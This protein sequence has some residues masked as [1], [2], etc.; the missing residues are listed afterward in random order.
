MSGEHGRSIRRS[1]SLSV[2]GSA[3]IRVALVHGGAVA[4][5]GLRVLLEQGGAFVVVAEAGKGAVLAQVFPEKGVVQVAVVELRAPFDAVRDT[6]RWLLRE[7]AIPVLA[8]GDLT[9]RVAAELLD[10]G[11]CGLLPADVEADE[12]QRACT[13]ASAGGYHVNTWIKGPVARGGK[14]KAQRGAG[15]PTAKQLEMLKWLYTGLTLEGIGVKMHIGRRGVETHRDA[16]FRKFG[17]HKLPL[18]LRV[19]MER[20][21]V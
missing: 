17:V 5:A 13:V 19:A 15:D 11:V 3:P 2:A 6:V 4:R 10:H 16:L 18:L 1:G 21:L 9:E 14:G 12:L 8:F 20:R 7:R